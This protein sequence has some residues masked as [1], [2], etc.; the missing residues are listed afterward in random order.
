MRQY[1]LSVLRPPVSKSGP[2]SSVPK[3]PMTYTT[4]AKSLDL[5]RQNI[6]RSIN[7]EIQTVIS[8]YI[9][10]FFKPGIEN[11]RNNLGPDSV[12]DD[13][14]KGMCRTILEEA[15]V[16]YPVFA[17]SN[18]S[19][20][21]NNRSAIDTNDADYQNSHSQ[22][23]IKQEDVKP[24][25]TSPSVSTGVKRESDTDS[26][27]S[28]LSNASKK[29]KKSGNKS[30]SGNNSSSSGSTNSTTN[31]SSSSSNSNSQKPK[32][33]S[34]PSRKH[35][36]QW[37]IAKLTTDTLFIMGAKANKALGFAQT[38][39]RLYVKHPGLFKYASDSDDKEWLSKNKL[40]PAT[41]GRAYIMLLEDIEK[42]ARDNKLNVTINYEDIKGFRVPDF[43]LDKM[44]AY[45]NTWKKQYAD[46]GQKSSTS[47]RKTTNNSS[48]SSTSASSNGGNN[49]P[50][51]NNSMASTTS[52]TNPSI[53]NSI[54]TSSTSVDSNS[55]TTTFTTL[56]PPLPPPLPLH[57]QPPMQQQP[58]H[59]AHNQPGLASYQ[60]HGTAPPT[61]TVIYD[62]SF[63]TTQPHD[64]TDMREYIHI[65]KPPPMY[66]GHSN[67]QQ[68]HPM[69][70]MSNPGGGY[71][72]PNHID[73]IEQA[74]S[75]GDW[76]SVSDRS[77]LQYAL[78]SSRSIGSWDPQDSFDLIESVTNGGLGGGGNMGET[79]PLLQISPDGAAHLSA[80]PLGPVSPSCELSAVLDQAF[81]YTD[82]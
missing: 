63:S 14:I 53:N 11:I 39:G 78:Q 56:N 55:S 5:L 30:S 35:V 33:P 70:Q 61:A 12:T 9:D 74:L 62:Q 23:Q 75:K 80:P 43:I 76:S 19:Q 18:P 40:M 41:G 68:Q 37:D 16:M 36:A 7:Q 77:L 49:Q 6:Q 48:S 51:T 58:Q 26:E 34:G 8:K 1:N 13:H 28:S 67:Q 46:E 42:L 66:P 50:T 57:P 59:N 52:V 4:A 45:I 44:K 79:S 27:A 24:P 38:R 29:M 20:N 81:Q 21:C 31:G 71:V 60:M 65:E 82:T 25:I 64:I 3:A 10:V 47:N 73:P 17:N 69:P 72:H 15:K 54:A 22:N 2:G 32:K